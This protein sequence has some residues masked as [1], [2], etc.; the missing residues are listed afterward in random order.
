MPDAS[1]C[2]VRR[3]AP[4]PLAVSVERV[5]AEAAP[6]T[7]L[8]RVQGSWP[9]VVGAAVAREAEAVAERGGEVTVACRSAAWAH[10]LEMLSVDLVDRLN[11][12]IAHSGGEAPVKGLRLVTRSAAG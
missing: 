3:L 8:A 11:R 5:A 12:A 9:G 4:R 1:G 6:A 10:E 2:G 7:L